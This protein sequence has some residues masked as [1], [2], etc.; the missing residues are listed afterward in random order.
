MQMPKMH[1]SNTFLVRLVVVGL[2]L[3]LYVLLVVVGIAYSCSFSGD[4]ATALPLIA[5]LVSA[6]VVS[7]LALTQPGEVPS[8][9]SFAAGET[10]GAVLRTVTTVYIVVWLFCGLASLLYGWFKPD[11]IDAIKTLGKAWLGIAVAAGYAYFGV[12]PPSHG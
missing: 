6:L 9:R 7:E 5:G 1:M 8:G 2:L 11:A 10:D 3:A 4:M 12:K